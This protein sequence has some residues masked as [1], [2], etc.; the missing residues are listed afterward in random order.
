MLC[1]R[2]LYVFGGVVVTVRK[3]QTFKHTSSST[4]LSK[5]A[6]NE[7]EEEAAAEEKSYDETQS[8]IER[9]DLVRGGWLLLNVLNSR[10]Y[11]SFERPALLYA[12]ERDTI[13]IFGGGNRRAENHL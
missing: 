5:N 7:Q 10:N 12:A 3:K 2:Q 6:T 11:I 1:G 8:Q 4:H 13:V 9:Y